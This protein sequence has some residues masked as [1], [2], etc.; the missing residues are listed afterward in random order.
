MKIVIDIPDEEYELDK[1]L[2]DSGMGSPAIH[3]ILDGIPYEERK[4]GKWV[5][6]HP[7]QE[8]DGGA[9]VCSCC[10]SG[11]YEVIPKTWKACPW[12]TALMEVDE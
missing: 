3:R 2:A 12:C 6:A 4:I 1:W 10:K 7:L 11:S 9:Y 8:N 5:L